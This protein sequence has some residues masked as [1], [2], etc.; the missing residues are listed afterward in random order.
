MQVEDYYELDPLKTQNSPVKPLAPK[1][2]RRLLKGPEKHYRDKVRVE[3]TLNWLY[4]NHIVFNLLPNEIVVRHLAR[5]TSLKTKALGSLDYLA[6]EPEKENIAVVPIVFTAIALVVRV[7]IPSPAE[8]SDQ[9]F[10][11]AVLPI[12]L[13]IPLALFLL[14]RASHR[15]YRVAAVA[16]WAKSWSTAIRDFRPGYEQDEVDG[17]A[18]VYVPYDQEHHTSPAPPDY[19]Q[20]QR[21][22][23]SS[24]SWGLATWSRR[25]K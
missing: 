25:T 6:E 7:L 19:R 8:N 11:L 17:K 9:N 1:Y 22:Q 20:E 15:N 10:D 3:H 14:L 16:A 18:G 23:K 5:D 21:P 12:I 2:F 24:R 13:F 4:S